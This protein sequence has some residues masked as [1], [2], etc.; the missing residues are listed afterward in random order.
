M[1]WG[2]INNSSNGIRI[3]SFT[4][5]AGRYKPIG[6]MRI[7]L[8][9]SNRAGQWGNT[10]VIDGM[11][12]KSVGGEEVAEKGLFLIERR[13]KLVVRYV[14]ENYLPLKSLFYGALSLVLLYFLHFIV[15]QGCLLRQPSAFWSRRTKH[16][17]CKSWETWTSKRWC[18]DCPSGVEKSSLILSLARSSLIFPSSWVHASRIL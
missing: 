10:R 7:V 14:A 5:I 8:T 1:V 12:F 11:L 17:L 3:L 15:R 9:S 18:Q 13:T 6:I 2:I 4:F 16:S